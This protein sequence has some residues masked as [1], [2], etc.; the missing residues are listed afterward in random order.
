MGE[1]QNQWNNQ[2]YINPQMYSNQYGNA[3][4]Q[5]NGPGIQFYQKKQGGRPIVKRANMLLL[6]T[7]LS[8]IGASYIYSI[9]VQFLGDVIPFLNSTMCSILV[10]QL[11]LII[12]SLVYLKIGNY[13]I[14]EFLHI[15][16][17][18]P[19]TILLLII[20]S[21]ACYPII[22]LCSYLSLQVSENVVGDTMT[23][24]F[25]EYP[26][27]VCVLVI[28]LLPCVVEEFL[29]RGALYYSYKHAG[30]VKA[31]VCTAILFGFFHM[32]LNQVSYALVLGLIMAILNEA[33]GSILSSMIV[34]FIINGTS[35]IASS[36]LFSKGGTLET[37]T[38]A[39]IST[40]LMI[41]SLVIMSLFSLVIL[42]LILW[43]MVYLEKRPKVI[44]EM[45]QNRKENRCAIMSPSLAIALIICIVMMILTQIVIMQSSAMESTEVLN[46]LII[47]CTRGF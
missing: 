43:A 35:V 22:S 14:K 8:Y 1:E 33:T 12:P 2:N 21:Y 6:V 46:E 31:C 11:S 32:N 19:V 25:T 10:S 45:W 37:D 23:G 30:V 29:F 18:H 13:K 27:W 44:K 7:L 20:F 36:V 34:H 39:T 28:A 40:S 38:S 5:T 15:K 17:L 9:L 16:M 26:I 42:G 41:I 24:L 47:A 3:Y 4:T